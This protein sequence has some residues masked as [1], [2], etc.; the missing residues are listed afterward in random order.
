MTKGWYERTLVDKA[1]E[2]ERLRNEINML[3]RNE[4]YLKEL[5]RRA[6]DALEHV[7]PIETYAFLDWHPY[8][9]L[10]DKLREAAK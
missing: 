4:L 10:K 7:L 1:C 8:Y 5:A 2:I 3:Q 9:E 6:A